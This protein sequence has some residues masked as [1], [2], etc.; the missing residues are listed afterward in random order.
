MRSTGIPHSKIFKVR[1]QNLYGSHSNIDC[2]Y[3]RGNTRL[4]GIPQSRIIKVQDQNLHGSESNLDQNYKKGNRRPLSK[5]LNR[6]ARVGDQNMYGSESSDDDMYEEGNLRP[7]AMP[8]GRNQIVL[9]PSRN[10]D[11]NLPRDNN[12]DDILGEVNNQNLY[13]YQST[14]DNI[15]LIS[16]GTGS[17][18][19]LTAN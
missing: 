1:N 10:S 11:D 13:G 4:A 19:S 2:F 7:V 9:S 6:I 17:Y 18:Q 5:P 12:F 16:E 15:N 8:L 14:R 3:E